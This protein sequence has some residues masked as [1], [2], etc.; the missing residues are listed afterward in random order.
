[1]LIETLNSIY[2]LDTNQKLFRKLISQ[3]DDVDGVWKSYDE[4]LQPIIGNSL[5][6]FIYYENKYC[7][8]LVT[9]TIKRI[10]L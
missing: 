10:V 6:I 8:Y 7:R 4:I 9:S 5:W 2:E 1:M 3:L